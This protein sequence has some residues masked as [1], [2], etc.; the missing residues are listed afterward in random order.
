MGGRPV[1][2]RQLPLLLTLRA[3]LRLRSVRETALELGVSDATVSRRLAELRAWLGDP[4]LIRVGNALHPT[5]RAVQFEAALAERLNALAQL[6][7]SGPAMAVRPAFTV[8]SSDAFHWSS[9]PNLLGEDPSLRLRHVAT[10]ACSPNVASALIQGDVDLYLG[11]A[12][13]LS[14]GLQRRRMF[15]ADFVTVLRANHPAALVPLDVAAFCALRHVLVTGRSPARSIVDEALAERGLRRSVA[16][17][18][19]SFAGALAMVASTDCVVTMP[20][21]PASAAAQRLPLVLLPVP[22]DLPTIAIYVYWHERSHA[23]PAHQRLRER[24]AEAVAT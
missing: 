5:E 16:L 12:L 11:P 6:L 9:F 20:R 23:D 8:A 2:E 22:L 17:E 7:A 24:L 4:L 1:N 3:L 18:T 13:G 10:E 19:P 21:A 15:E 14:E